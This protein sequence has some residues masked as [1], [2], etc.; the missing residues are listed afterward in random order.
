[1]T[2]D[3]PIE[4]VGEPPRSHPVAAGGQRQD[5]QPSHTGRIVGDV[6]AVHRRTASR[7]ESGHI[8]DATVGGVTH[9]EVV[10]QVDDGDLDGIVGKR[11]AIHFLT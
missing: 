3:D 9:S 5:R 2:P 7:P 11:V 4:P 1:M 10:I 8:L 6:I